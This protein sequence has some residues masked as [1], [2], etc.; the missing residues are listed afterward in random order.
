ML[1]N[2]PYLAQERTALIE[3]INN[4]V[5]LTIAMVLP[6]PLAPMGVAQKGGVWAGYT[7]SEIDI[8][9]VRRCFELFEEYVQ[10]HDITV[11]PVVLTILHTIIRHQMR[12]NFEAIWAN[13]NGKARTPHWMRPFYALMAIDEIWVQKI[14]VAESTLF[15]RASADRSFYL[16]PN[17]G[18]D[19]DLRVHEGLQLIDMRNDAGE[20]LRRLIVSSQENFDANNVEFIE[21]RTRLTE[22]FLSL[23]PDIKRVEQGEHPFFKAFYAI[24][25]KISNRADPSIMLSDIIILAYLLKVDFLQLYDPTC[26]PVTDETHR[27][28]SET[29]SGAEYNAPLSYE[30]ERETETLMRQPSGGKKKKR[31]TKNSIKRNTKSSTIKNSA[32]NSTKKNKVFV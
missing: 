25:G 1:E 28:R 20:L 15:S 30:A 4:H 27:Y 31:S 18:E 22:Y 17:V 11:N 9:L 16:R 26:R 2:Y 29:R 13:F 6:G 19:P 21:C 23:Y 32:K 10:E 8:Q 3:Y 7:T 5:K 14:L 12:A 24:L